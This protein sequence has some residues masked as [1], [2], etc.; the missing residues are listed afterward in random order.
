MA[1][2]VQQSKLA[3][4][5]PPQRQH[6]PR[7]PQS[8]RRHEPRRPAARRIAAPGAEDRRLTEIIRDNAERVSAIIDNVLQLSRREQRSSSSCRLAELDRGVPRE[9]C[10][11]MQWP[12]DRGCTAAAAMADRRS[13]RRIPTQLHQIVWNLCENATQVRCRRRPRQ[14]HRDPLRAHEPAAPGPSW[15]WRT[16][17]PASRP[18]MPSD[19]RA[20]LHRRHAARASACS[21]R[22]NWRRPTAPSALRAAHRRRQHFRMVFAIRAAGRY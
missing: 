6:R 4:L 11:T 5:G 9:F 14:Q 18:S 10:E 22:A 3:A 8:R 2:K 7:D 12:R 13:A 15:K 19:L 17:A 1:E 20:L 16:A 21:W